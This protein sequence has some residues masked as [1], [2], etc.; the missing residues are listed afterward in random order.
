MK[1]SIFAALAA[2]GFTATTLL[3]Q[4]PVGQ[5]A[6][7]PPE[8]GTAAAADAARQAM[9]DDRRGLVERNLQL[10]AEEAKRFRPVYDE[11]E[12]ELDAIVKRQNRAVLD[13]VNTESSLTDGNAKRLANEVLSAD[14]DETKLRAKTFKRV[15]AVL[16]VRKAVRFLQIENK[17][18]TL[19]RYDVTAQV[20]LV[21]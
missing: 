16:P 9:R 10:S 1:N 20:P 21:K 5:P 14:A 19:A 12:K 11:Y 8:R 2:A 13:Y 4:P 7:P 18:R 15:S 17:L 6:P 3:A